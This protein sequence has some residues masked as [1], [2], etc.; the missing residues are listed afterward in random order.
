VR[1][2]ASGRSVLFPVRVR[3]NS[4][5]LW[6]VVLFL[7]GSLLFRSLRNATEDSETW[8]AVLVQVGALVV[9]IGA[10]VLVARRLR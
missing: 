2:A 5:V 10:V 7:G 8:V 3:E 1:R 4:T 9:L 6:T